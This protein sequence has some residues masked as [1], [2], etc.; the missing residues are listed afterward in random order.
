MSTQIVKCDEVQ[1]MM[2]L[3]EDSA[4]KK[5]YKDYQDELRCLQG[6]CQHH[7]V[8]DWSKEYTPYGRTLARMVQTCLNCS[9]IIAAKEQ[10]CEC[11]DYFRSAD[12]KIGDGNPIPQG[13]VYCNNCYPVGM[14][15]HQLLRNRRGEWD[16]V[17]GRYVHGKA[18]KCSKCDQ[19]AEFFAPTRLCRDHW[20]DWYVD[21]LNPSPE[22]RATVASEIRSQMRRAKEHGE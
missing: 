20:I 21:S 15:M 22:M 6:M 2:R 10:C 8:A 18:L 13:Q 4:A 3:L 11:Y 19:R 9:K 17:K 14:M 7:F 1:K 12:I 16:E 5:L